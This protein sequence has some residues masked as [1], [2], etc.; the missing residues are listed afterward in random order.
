MTDLSPA[1][2]AERLASVRTYTA[3]ELG[4]HRFY[5]PQGDRLDT[6]SILVST[7]TRDA[8]IAALRDWK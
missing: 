8:I 4:A 3:S 6:E 7:T 1:E 2:L 5:S